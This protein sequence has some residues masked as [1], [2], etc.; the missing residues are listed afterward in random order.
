MRLLG[1]VLCLI[2]S[3]FALQGA[4]VLPGSFMTGD[5]TWLVIGAAAVVAGI[6]LLM[7]SFRV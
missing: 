5:R 6:T 1:I 4:G 3:V 7:R 2:G